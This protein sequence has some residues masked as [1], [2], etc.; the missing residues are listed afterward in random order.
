MHCE[1]GTGCL[2]GPTFGNASRCALL[3]QSAELGVGLMLCRRRCLPLLLAP[4]CPRSWAAWRR[5]TCGSTTITCWCC[6]RCCASASTASSEQAR[7]RHTP[8]PRAAAQGCKPGR[9][10]SSLASGACHLPLLLPC[11]TLL[12]VSR[13]G[14]LTPPPPQPALHA[15]ARSFHRPP[16]F[17]AA[18][19]SFHRP[20]RRCG[21]FLHSPFPS[22]EI[23]RTF[24]RREEIIR[25][26][27]N[28][29][30]RRRVWTCCA[31]AWPTRKLQGLVAA[32][33]ALLNFHISSGF[34]SH[35]SGRLEG[36]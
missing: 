21:I 3:P 33:P 22:S 10:S 36:T 18:A 7:R 15:A 35:I 11:R 24:P 29:G 9:H 23:F 31:A 28:A 8:H 32:T 20:P 25:S 13:R 27:L 16:L 30:T 34:D 4:R 19:R 14:H 17:H 26:M 12:C 5:I 1:R 6:P 2:G